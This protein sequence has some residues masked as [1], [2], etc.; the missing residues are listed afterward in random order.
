MASNARVV[1]SVS[2]L[3]A[4]LCVQAAAQTNF[5]FYALGLLW[6]GSVCKKTAG[7]CKTQFAPSPVADFFVTGLYTYSA[8]GPVSKCPGAP[9]SQQLLQTILSDLWNYWQ[10]IKC[11]SHPDNVINFWTAVWSNYGT[12]TGMD[13]VTYFTTAVNQRK[14][15]D[16]LNKL[17]QYQIAPND[18]FYR[19]QVVV[20]ALRWA[21]GVK[22]LLFC[23]NDV[24]G[25][26]QLQEVF[27]CLNKITYQP[28][29]CPASWTQQCPERFIFHSFNVNML[30]SASPME[31]L[32]GHDSA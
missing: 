20:D 31:G 30:G 4:L 12:C 1:A 14:N 23:S 22:T 32:L 9:F 19:T 5:D 18:M 25:K 13:E 3:L 24:D 27:I 28:I 8:N 21:Y 6:P 29:D 11:P 15:F 16:V 26:V 10:V 2:F 17:S 7:C